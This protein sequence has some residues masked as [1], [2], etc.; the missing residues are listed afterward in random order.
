VAF[1]DWPDDVLAAAGP[2]GGAVGEGQRCRTIWLD[3]SGDGAGDLRNKAHI[4][5]AIDAAGRADTDDGDVAIVQLVGQTGDGVDPAIGMGSGDQ[6]VEARF[7]D[8]RAPR[9]Q[10]GDFRIAD[11]DPDDGVPLAGNAS[12]GGGAD[13]TQSENG[14]F[15]EN[16]LK[17]ATP[18]AQAT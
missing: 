4:V 13:V 18:A 12:C 1:D 17:V 2:H 11:I 8:R 9:I 3:R 7:I 6:I 5:R 10:R 15:H 14:N 16:S